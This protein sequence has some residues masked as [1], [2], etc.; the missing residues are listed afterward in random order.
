MPAP[1]QF[2]ASQ[3]HEIL[4][5]REF[6]LAPVW[7]TFRN[8]LLVL[9]LI[10]VFALV[11]MIMLRRACDAGIKTANSLKQQ[12]L[13]NLDQLASLQE[14][15][16]IFRLYSY[17][18]LFA[19]EADRP[20]KAA[21]VENVERQIRAELNLIETLLPDG[22]GRQLATNLAA[23]CGDLSREFGLVRGLV[24]KDFA[25][26]MKG[27]DQD[28]PPKI[29]RVT[30]AANALKDFGHHFS[31]GQANAAVSSFDSIQKNAILFASANIAVAFGAVVFVMMAARRTRIQLSETLARL[32]ER[33][34]QLQRENAERRQAE[35]ELAHERELLRSLLETAEDQIYFKDLQSRFTRCGTAQA[36]TFGLKSAEELVGKCDFDFFTAEHARPA[37]EDEQEIIRTGKPIIGKMEKETH[38]NGRVTWALTSKMPLRNPAGEI[39]GTFGISKDI[40]AMKDAEAERQMIELQLRQAQKMEA[41]GQLAAG[42]AHE[43][44]TPTQ[45]VGD[46]TRFLKDAFDNIASLLRS[47][48]E[49]LA[50]ARQNALTPEIVEHA[51]EVLAASDLEYLFAQIPQAIQETLEGVERVTKIVRA[52]KEFSHPGGKEKGAADLNKAIES[53]VTVA[54]NEWK[55][56]SDL[57]LDLDPELPL[58]PCFISEFNQ[59]MLNLVV[60]A[61]HAIGDVVKQ[62]PGTKGVITVQTRRNQG[63]VVVRVS[64]TG[65]GIAEAHRPHIFEPFFTTKEVGKGSGQG[66]AFVY[67]SIVKKHGGTVTFETQTGKGTTFIIHLPVNPL[68]PAA[69]VSNP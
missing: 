33:S 57:K 46:N 20:A 62:T 30:E 1:T 10:F 13:P 41:I 16:A 44:N 65:G 5:D 60:N 7:A 52:M 4:A 27:L 8:I 12:G 22:P 68:N 39:I 58:V 45:Y 18:Y 48:G 24:D 14:H 25:E 19:Q 35:T 49:L 43:I 55:Y 29:Q 66:L 6:H 38:A 37:F 40:T 56:V 3:D 51:G 26:A 2:S 59:A 54:R 63:S 31:N 34:R 67:N 9:L 32:A 17:E 47:H 21:A 53:T 36:R 15:L 61:A 69:K 11:Q 23:A 64:D 50:A 42:I 28:I